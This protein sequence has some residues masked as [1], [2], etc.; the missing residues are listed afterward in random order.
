[1]TSNGNYKLLRL[2]NQQWLS[3]CTLIKHEKTQGLEEGE[4][5]KG[6][7]QQYPEGA[8]KKIQSPKK[9]ARFRNKD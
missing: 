4:A 6:Q 5:G 1:M 3:W 7:Q 9:Q 8:G 2:C